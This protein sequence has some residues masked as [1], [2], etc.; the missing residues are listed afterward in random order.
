MTEKYKLRIREIILTLAGVWLFVGGSMAEYAVAQ[1]GR[2]GVEARLDRVE[3]KA[4]VLTIEL[5]KRTLPIVE[6][7]KSL[8]DDVQAMKDSQTKMADSQTLTN[9]AI[10]GSVGGFLLTQ[11]L[12]MMFNYKRQQSSDKS[13]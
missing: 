5:E 2:G 13:Q 4:E 7:M 6:Q 3:T 9:R 1:T 8:R 12:T 11:L 10:I